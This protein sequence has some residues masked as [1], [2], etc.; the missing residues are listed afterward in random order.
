MSAPIEKIIAGNWKMNLGPKEAQ[1]F[2]TEVRDTWTK[3]LSE[4]TRAR[5]QSQA[6]QLWVFPP[7]VTLQAAQEAAKGLP[8]T[9][10]AQNAHG[11]VSGAFTGEL[12]ASMLAQVG[13]QTVLLGHSERRQFFGETDESLLKR[14]EGLIS[15]KVQLL[16]CVG[17]TR[18]ERE[19]GKTGDVL[20]SQL[21]LLVAS[22]ILKAAFESGQAHLAYEPVWAIG[23]GLTAS[24][25]QA[26][27]AH[28][29]LRTEIREKVSPKAAETVRILYGGSVTPESSAALLSRP[30]IDGALVGGASL[31][32]ASF[33]TILENASSAA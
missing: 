4:R 28:Q 15:Q 13:V 8:I 3:G 10:G 22:P 21:R 27:E 25:E 7:A 20:L 5:L 31:K 1:A 19:A 9:V 16:I 17:E 32:S 24:P 18:A 33:L 11:S 2:M 30:G 14:A 29:I 23:T 12:S 26:E 6:W